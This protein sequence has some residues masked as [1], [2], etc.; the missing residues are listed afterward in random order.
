VSCQTAGKAP[1][2][3]LTYKKLEKSVNRKLAPFIFLCTGICR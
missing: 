3:R 1:E 2:R